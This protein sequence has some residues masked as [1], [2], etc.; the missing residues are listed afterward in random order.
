MEE[1]SLISAVFSILHNGKKLY[2]DY[3]KQSLY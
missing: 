2:P 3:P 1:L